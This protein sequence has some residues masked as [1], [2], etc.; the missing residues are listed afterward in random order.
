MDAASSLDARVTAVV[1]GVEGWPKPGVRFTDVS[2]VW[3][4][5]PDLFRELVGRLCGRFATEP[6]AVLVA[7]EARAFLF[8]GAMANEL[9]C[10]V[11]MARKGPRLPR[12]VVTQEYVS[13]YEGGLLM[14]VHADALGPG[15]A[16]LVVDD[17]LAM[18]WSAVGAVRLVEK[19]GAACTGVAVAIE[20]G[21]LPGRANVAEHAGTPLFAA[22]TTQGPWHA[23]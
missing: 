7:I 23:P 17:V 3:E 1:R 5:R 6:P 2:A 14:G 20:L 13:G 9:G 8:A 11:V 19:A 21:H 16:A 10:R 18:G 12:D 22:A 4:R 15:D